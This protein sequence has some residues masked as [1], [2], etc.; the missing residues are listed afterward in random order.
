MPTVCVIG[1]SRYFGRRLL[2]RLRDAGWAV[3]VVNRGSAA[4]P[5]GVEQLTADRND[6]AAL[7]AALGDRRFDVVIDQVCSD[8]TTA[9]L[10]HRVFAGRTGR[11]VL[12][13]SVEV[14]SALDAADPL[15]EEAFDAARHPLTFELPADPAAAYAEGKRQAEAV[16]AQTPGLPY[17]AVRCAHVLGGGAADFTGRLDHY[18]TRLRTSA[19]IAVHPESRPATF[20]AYQEIADFLLWVA[21]QEFTGPVNACSHGELDVTGLCALIGGE[22]VWAAAAAATG[23][24]SPFSFERHYAMDNARAERLGYRFGTVTDWLPGVL[25]QARAA[26]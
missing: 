7:T 3:T 24:A 18:L 1:G 23:G 15:P 22:P 2:E 19:P 13:S 14:Y 10:A 12:T 26:H 8:P 25:A 6:E 11:Y 21:G 9:A 16:F 4:A 5:P 20:I 17:V